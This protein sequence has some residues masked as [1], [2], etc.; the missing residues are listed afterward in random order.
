MLSEIGFKEQ[1]E[2]ER[3]S[4]RRVT[5]FQGKEYFFHIN[6]YFCI[7]RKGYG[8]PTRGKK[9]LLSYCLQPIRPQSWRGKSLAAL[10]AELTGSCAAAALVLLVCTTTQLQIAW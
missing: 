3:I 1:N 10:G 4:H 8:E 9:Y 6:W 5:F 2:R 7:C